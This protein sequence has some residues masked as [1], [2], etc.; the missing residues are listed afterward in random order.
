MNSPEGWEGFAD[1]YHNAPDSFKP[2]LYFVAGLTFVVW[3]F[4][5]SI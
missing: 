1:W 5:V 4:W 2:T 3:T